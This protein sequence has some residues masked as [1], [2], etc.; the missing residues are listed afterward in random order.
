MPD[1]TSPPRVSVI[2]PCRNEALTVEHVLTSVLRDTRDDCEVIVADGH[3]DDGTRSIIN[4]VAGANPRVRV[5]DNP[6]RNQSAGLNAA[7]RASQGRFVVR[8]DAHTRY[9]SDYVETCVRTLEDTGAEN[10]GGPQTADLEIA[11]GYVARAIACAHDCALAV[12]GASLHDPHYEGPTDAVAY[13]CWRREIFD[14]VGFFDEE[15][16]RNEDG[17]HNR[18]IVI[19]GGTVWQTPRIRSWYQPRATLGALW[20]QYGQYGYW[21]VFEIR[22]LRAVRK[23]RQLVPGAFLFFLLLA[24]VLAVWFPFAAI[25]MLLVLCAYAIFLVVATVSVCTHARSV[26]IAPMVP[27]AFG[28]MHGGYGT[29]FLHGAWDFLVTGR[30]PRV[31][32]RKLTR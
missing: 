24:S 27:L 15:L 3:S 6:R 12:G 16:E 13:G 18:R 32:Y 29:G 28:A 26:R 7:I 14:R 17:E 2:I 22:K 19:S 10:V 9:A 21:K 1:A 30:T 25:A 5:V 23:W 8:L 20:R 31:G 11:T 4:R